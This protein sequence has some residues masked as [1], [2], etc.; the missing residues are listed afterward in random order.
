MFLPRITA[1]LEKWRLNLYASSGVVNVAWSLVAFLQTSTFSLMIA[2]FPLLALHY[3]PSGVF[4][5]LSLVLGIFDLF[6][7]VSVIFATSDLFPLL[8]VE[9][10]SIGAHFGAMDSWFRVEVFREDEDEGKR[11]RKGWG[12]EVGFQIGQPSY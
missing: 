6:P 9:L 7:L 12:L 3:A 10:A 1:R 2:R 5:L 4:Y 11:R 8:A